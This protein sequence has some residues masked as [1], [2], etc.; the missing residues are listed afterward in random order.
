M[1][2]TVYNGTILNDL[3]TVQSETLYTNNT[4]KNVRIV[5]NYLEAGGATTPGGSQEIEF[6]FGSTDNPNWKKACRYGKKCTTSGCKFWHPGD[7]SNSGATTPGGTPKGKGK[8][9]GKG[10][11]S[12]GQRRALLRPTSTIIPSQEM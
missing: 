7:P 8:G 1:T 12:K 4:G 11:S 3:S 5:F 6:Y 2:A 10:K 9:K